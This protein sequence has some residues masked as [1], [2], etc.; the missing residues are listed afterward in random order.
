MSQRIPFHVAL[1]TDRK[2]LPYTAAAALSAIIN[3][4]DCDIEIHLIS[5][6]IESSGL[7]ELSQCIRKAGGKLHLYRV[8]NEQHTAF[9]IT[10]DANRLSSA[11]YYRI[12]LP[13]ILPR[14]IER[15]L[16]ID[17]DTIVL[18][19]L[20]PLAEINLT[21]KAL[22]AV[23]DF[24]LDDGP[25]RCA[26]LGYSPQG[27]Y[28]NSGVLLMNLNYWR[29][30]HLI[31]QCLETFHQH[32]ERIVYDDQDLL[33]AVVSERVFW[34][35]ADWNAQDICY[36]SKFKKA[37]HLSQE[38]KLRLRTPSIVHFTGTMKPWHWKSMHPLRKAYFHALSATPWK[39]SSF[40]EKA[41][42]HL[43]HYTRWLMT[44][45]HLT[46]KRYDTWKIQ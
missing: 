45:L 36:R 38:D 35:T 4:P 29:E 25:K 27:G 19:S 32:P 40:Q 33:N 22:A 7:Q 21:G 41:V 12:F 15:V 1:C 28:F 13:D 16:Y 2:Y 30:N 8:T 24:N 3:S 6:D 14:D 39:K 11:A 5:P 20:K 18:N 34:L 46:K 9:H 10:S 31:Q 42:F 43:R 17:G 37:L 26:R 44:R 23:H